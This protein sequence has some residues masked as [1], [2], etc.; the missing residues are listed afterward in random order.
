MTGLLPPEWAWARDFGV[1]GYVA[2]GLAAL[3]VVLAVA[4]QRLSS[5]VPGADAAG[6]P[7]QSG[8]I[9]GEAFGFQVREVGARIS[10]ALAHDGDV[11]LFGLGGAGKSQL[12]AWAVRR[13][14]GLRSWR[15][16]RSVDLLVWVAASSRDAIVAAYAQAAHE[17]GVGGTDDSEKAAGRFLTWLQVSGRRWLVVLD[18]LDDLDA[19]Q[20]LWPPQ[21]P[22]GRVLVTTRRR[23]ASLAAPGRTQMEIGMFTAAEARGYLVGKVPGADLAEVDGLAADLRWLPLALA[24]AGAFMANE[25]MDVATY[26]RLLGERG[27]RLSELLADSGLPDDYARPVSTTLSLSVEEADKLTPAG[28]ARPMLWLLSVLD[29]DGVPWEVAATD[30]VYRWLATSWGGGAVNEVQARG[31]VNALRRFSLASADERV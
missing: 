24:H 7:R 5:V 2:G 6:W 1:M 4:V 25:R 19:V 30:A 21:Q 16:R 26:R 28:L 27:R 13:L 20:G 22:A 8:V 10:S 23:E 12:A 15:G 11:V 3:L 29:P 14:W 18:G 9:P 17:V 31:A